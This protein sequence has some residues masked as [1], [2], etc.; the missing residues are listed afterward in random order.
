MTGS[1]RRRAVDER[2]ADREALERPFPT[3]AILQREGAQG[4]RYDYVATHTVIRRLNEAT[5]N[6]WDFRITRFEWRGDLLIT[7]GE[8]TLPGLGTR[9]GTGVQKVGERTEDL[10]KGS[11]SDCLKN[12]ARMFGVALDL[13]GPDYEAGEISRPPQHHPA[14]EPPENVTQPTRNAA[15]PMDPITRKDAKAA[16]TFAHDAGWTD[17]EI[18]HWL[19]AHR[20]KRWGVMAYHDL[21][22]FRRDVTNGKKPAP[23]EPGPQTTFTTT[24][25][26]LAEMTAGIPE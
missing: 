1:V 23:A 16:Q 20:L 2:Q 15:G 4:R 24:D 3:H 9:S 17:D 6:R 10:V 19:D 13:Y 26:E 5:E 25:D 7:T 12:C 11:A 18:M 14:Q 8:L 21:G 22:A